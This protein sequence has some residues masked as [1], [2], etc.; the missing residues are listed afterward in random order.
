MGRIKCATKNADTICQKVAPIYLFFPLQFNFTNKNGVTGHHAFF[1][2][3]FINAD[4]FHDALEAMNGLVV[5]P[6][7]HSCCTF[8][9]LS[10]APPILLLFFQFRSNW[11]RIP[12][13]RQV[14]LLQILLLGEIGSI[15]RLY[16]I[17]C[18]RFDLWQR[19]F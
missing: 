10:L 17:K 16:I 11:D 5:F 13:C 2:K 4:E 12:W 15:H 3:G 7:G 9:G 6:I 1:A 8:N 18:V 19:K 14:I